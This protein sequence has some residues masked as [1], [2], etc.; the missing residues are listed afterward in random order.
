MVTVYEA[1]YALGVCCWYGSAL[2]NGYPTLWVFQLV[3][4]LHA[5]SVLGLDVGINAWAVGIYI[6]VHELGY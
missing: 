4:Y 2:L 6:V 5:S 3:D 1:S